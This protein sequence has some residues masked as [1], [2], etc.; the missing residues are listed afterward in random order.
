MFEYGKVPDVN[1]YNT[2]PYAYTSDLLEYG[3]DSF[4]RIISGALEKQSNKWTL[5]KWKRSKEETG[6]LIHKH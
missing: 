2:I 4:I 1:S 6:H 5:Y 3:W